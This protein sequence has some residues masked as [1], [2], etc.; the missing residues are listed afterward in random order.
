MTD[1]GKWRVERHSGRGMDHWRLKLETIKAAEA[2]TR[3]DKIAEK[4]RQG[5][6]RL[7]RPDG[8]TEFIV[9]APRLR[10]RW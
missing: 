5:G 2:K 10:T 8:K 1:L 6:V 4:L 9:N 7:I 3:F